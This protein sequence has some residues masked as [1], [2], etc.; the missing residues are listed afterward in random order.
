MPN[1]K[2]NMPLSKSGIA[3]DAV[4]A[5]ILCCSW[6]C[7]LLSYSKLPETIPTHFDLTGGADAFGEKVQLFYVLS[8]GTIFFIGIYIL[9]FFPHKLNLVTSVTEES[10]V[11]Q[12]TIAQ[13]AMRFINLAL[14]IT[15]SYLSA[16]SVYNALNGAVNLDPWMTPAILV[17]LFAPLVYYFMQS[18]KC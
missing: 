10:A 4:S 14:A 5:L 16:K 7:L 15:F 8:I 13:N 3:V 1:P 9:N 17:L 6:L 12:Y 11:Y 18:A 2:V